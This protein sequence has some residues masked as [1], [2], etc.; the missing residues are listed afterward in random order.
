MLGNFRKLFVDM[1]H[2]DSAIPSGILQAMEYD[3]PEGY[4]YEDLGNGI[5]FLK[6]PSGTSI[7]AKIFI[8]GA[9]KEKLHKCQYL[10]DYYNYAINLQRPIVLLP[11]DNGLY[12]FDEQAFSINQI[13][14]MPL[15]DMKVKDGSF[16][17]KVP[18]F[19]Y[20]ISVKMSLFDKERI[21]KL[22]RVSYDSLD[23]FKFVSDEKKGFVIT[24]IINKT[25][26]TVNISVFTDIVNAGSVKNVCDSI[27]WFNGFAK[28]EIIMYDQRMNPNNKAHITPYDDES[29]QFWNQLLE[30]EKIF[31]VNFDVTQGIYE[32]DVIRVRE[33][34]RSLVEKKPFR[35]NESVSQLEASTIDE[36]EI[37]IGAVVGQN[38]FFRFL[39]RQSNFVMGVKLNYV[40]IKY[41]FNAKITTYEYK[42]KTKKYVVLLENGQ[43]NSPMFTSTLYFQNESE[44]NSFIP[45]EKE[46][47]PE[48]EKAECIKEVDYN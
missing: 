31:N 35:K 46:K 8:E 26:P 20:E 5:C 34:Y 7:K 22:K 29:V 32:R 21:I 38:I 10:D 41:I 14:S 25:E 18:R 42:E 36:K 47:T 33:L 15:Q 40:G 37:N 12:Y 19:E 23:N 16:E 9:T 44:L 4:S 2:A 30:L 1:P 28:G 45:Y 13:M 24:M 48:F 27:F 43:K 17:L 11:D 39:T 6:I 3:L